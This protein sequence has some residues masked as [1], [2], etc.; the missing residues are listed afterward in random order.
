MKRL[1]NS[2]RHASSSSEPRAG[3]SSSMI[4]TAAASSALDTAASIWPA[5]LALARLEK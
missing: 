1:V 3:V 4:A 2:V 5:R